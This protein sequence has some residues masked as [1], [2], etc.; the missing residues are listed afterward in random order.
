[1]LKTMELYDLDHTLAKDYLKQFEYPW[2]ALKGI[3]ALILELGP[4]LGEEY[5]EV[6]PSV[7]VHKTATVAPT[8]FIGGPAIIGANTEVRHCAY[9]RES[10]LV[11]ENCV[12]GNSTEV[13][14]AILFDGVQIPHFNYAGD[15]ILGYKV[16]MGGGTMT[17]N[18]KSDKSLV[19]VRNGK[20][21]I[22]TGLKKFGAILGDHV[23]VGANTLLNPGTV[24]GCNSIVYPMA[25]VRGVVPADSIWKLDG[26]IV[27]REQR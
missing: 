12:V 26:T 20:E 7:W 15:S 6:S 9:I 21:R 4:M 25:C 19:T 5:T 8:A 16:H 13:K 23:E 3:K 27:K 22:E 18:V 1:M 10:A 11:G 14:N 17:S 2:Q 24:V